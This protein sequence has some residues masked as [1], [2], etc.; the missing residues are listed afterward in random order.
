M[1]RNYGRDFASTHTTTPMA[2]GGDYRDI[3]VLIFLGAH[4]F[5]AVSRAFQNDLYF[6]Q[7]GSV[8]QH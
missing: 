1:A 2:F 8:T 4:D 6:Q 3:I 7:F 5:C